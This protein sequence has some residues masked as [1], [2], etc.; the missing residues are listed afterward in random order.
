MATSK[1]YF[2]VNTELSEES[3]YPLV[4]IDEN[5]Q[6]IE[7]IN[8]LIGEVPD[9]TGNRPLVIVIPDRLTTVHF[10]SMPLLNDKKAQAAIPYALEDYTAQDLSEL[11]F[12]FDR[13]FYKNGQYIVFS[14][15][16][17]WLKTLLTLLKDHHIEPNDITT[18]W[19]ALSDN[20]FALHNQTLLCHSESINGAIPLTMLP[21]I[22]DQLALMET[23]T[24][25]Q[26]D[27]VN[28]IPDVLKQ[29]VS[30]CDQPWETWVSEQLSRSDYIALNQ[31][32]F[33]SQ[34]EQ[35]SIRHALWL[36]GGSLA[37]WLAIWLTTNILSLHHTNEEIKRIDDKIAV[38]YRQF[39][40]GAKRIISPKFRISQKLKTQGSGGETGLLR[41]LDKLAAPLKANQVTPIQLSYQDQR[42]TLKLIAN[43]FGH[44]EK[45]MSALKKQP[46]KAKQLNANRNEDKVEATVEIQI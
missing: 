2:F 41:L 30:N 15:D 24:I 17:H 11:H 12:A 23:A 32:P 6:S 10:V 36:A 38:I 42:L 9:K 27:E 8:C 44:L 46:V 45:F 4:L 31:G 37:I 39:F 34:Q 40:P 29:F 7:Q 13:R 18:A 35:T 28:K 19:F 14:C 3:A 22:K 43:N 26:F 25:F 21:M 5:G 33:S 1:A 16:K 20:Q